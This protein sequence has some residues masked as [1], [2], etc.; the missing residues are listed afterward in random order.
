M[1]SERPSS[2]TAVYARL[3]LRVLLET[4]IVAALAY[5]GVHRGD[6]TAAKVV[7][8][9]GAP[10]V[11]FGIWGAIDFRQ[12]GRLAETLRLIEEL[13]ISGL[14]ALAVYSSGL[15]AIGIAIAV[16]T[17]AYHAFVYV[18]GARLLEPKTQSPH[19]VRQSRNSSREVSQ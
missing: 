16:L 1:S 4:A 6:S 13:V 15:H 10:L 19:N 7:L 12:A 2:G 14:A 9:I 3:A 11:G 17:V 5:W 8:G 18:L